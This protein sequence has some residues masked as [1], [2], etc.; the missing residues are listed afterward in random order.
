MSKMIDEKV[1]T[2]YGC[3]LEGTFKEVMARL[4]F[5][6]DKHGSTAFI[7]YEPAPYDDDYRYVVYVPR[8]ETN[9]ERAKRNNRELKYLEREREYDLRKLKELKEKYEI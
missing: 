6:L 1:D 5:Y 8:P 9:M 2:I 3:E 7:R 4:D